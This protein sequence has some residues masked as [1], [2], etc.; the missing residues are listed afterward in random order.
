VPGEIP[1]SQEKQEIRF[2][3]QPWPE[4]IEQYMMWLFRPKISQRKIPSAKTGLKQMRLRLPKARK[5]LSQN[6]RSSPRFEWTF[7]HPQFFSFSGCNDL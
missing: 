5:H 6:H 7:F 2:L 4:Q 3:P 1:L